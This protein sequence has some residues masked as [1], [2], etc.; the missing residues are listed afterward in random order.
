MERLEALQSLTACREADALFHTNEDEKNYRK[1]EEKKELKRFHSDQIVSSCRV[2]ESS[3]ALAV[4][5]IMSYSTCILFTYNQPMF[6]FST[7]VAGYMT[8]VKRPHQFLRTVPT[9][10]ETVGIQS[11][12]Y[13]NLTG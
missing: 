10:G 8:Y 9:L 13:I 3:A 4:T 12:P 5:K 11:L 2:H 6:V 1:F 7:I